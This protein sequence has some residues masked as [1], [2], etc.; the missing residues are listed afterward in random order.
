MRVKKIADGKTVYFVYNG[1]ESLIEYSA[2][3]SKYTY[4]IYAGTQAVAEESG[5]VIKFY[6]KDHLGSTRV[7]TDTSGAKIAEYIYEPFGKVIAGTDGEQ[8]F[9]GKKEDSTGLIYFGARFYDPEIGRFITQD[10]AKIGQNW[11]EYCYNNPLRNIDPDGCYPLS[12][13]GGNPEKQAAVHTLGYWNAYQAGQIAQNRLKAAYDYSVRHGMGGNALDN[14]AD[15]Y[16]HFTWN[17]ENTNAF[18]K[19][20][21][22]TIADNHETYG[23][24]GFG[25]SS[26]SKMDLWNNSLGRDFASRFSGNVSDSLWGLALAMGLPVTNTNDS[27][28]SSWNSHNDANIP[29]WAKNF[30]DYAQSQGMS[31]DQAANTYN[32]NKAAIQDGSYFSGY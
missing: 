26:S 7:V 6:H 21:A 19:D 29:G 25:G 8:S 27:R 22:K 4:F 18:G 23:A 11:Y 14:E 12:V 30:L 31:A 20:K 5:G 24:D 9:T 13:T 17:A 32:Q 28:L 2:I 10:P 15:A 3:D 16:R 1:N